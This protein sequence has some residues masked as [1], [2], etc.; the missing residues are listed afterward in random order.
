MCSEGANNYQTSLKIFV[1]SRRSSLFYLR[2][3]GEEKSLTS[4]TGRIL[5]FFER[6]LTNS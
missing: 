2:M 4:L 3:N 1:T 6:S 5:V